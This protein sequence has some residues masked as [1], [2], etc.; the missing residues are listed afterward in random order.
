MPMPK[1]KKDNPVRKRVGELSDMMRVAEREGDL[2]QLGLTTLKIITEMALPAGLFL[3]TLGY[4]ARG[5][6]AMSW[7]MA[8]RHVGISW[9]DGDQRLHYESD[10][11]GDVIKEFFK[12]VAKRNH[13]K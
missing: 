10:S 4:L 13:Q 12:Q 6:I 5:R 2:E 1:T 11:M 9:A 7:N 3:T 8:E